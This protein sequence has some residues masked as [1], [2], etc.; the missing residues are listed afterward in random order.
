M[1]PLAYKMLLR[2]GVFVGMLSLC[3]MFFTPVE[4]PGFMVS[5]MS[6]CVGAAMVG[7]A[8]FFIRRSQK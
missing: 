7:L 1:S 4:R 2:M 8:A 3:M 5:A 6:L